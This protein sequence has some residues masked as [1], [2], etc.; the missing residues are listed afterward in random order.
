MA[1]GYGYGKVILFGEHFVVYGVP[2]IAAGV[3]KKTIATVEPGDNPGA[4]IIDNRPAVEG[5]KEKYVK[6][7]RESLERIRLLLGIDF[8]KNPI[9]ITL[10]GD[11]YCASGVGASAAS[12]VAMARAISQHFG[13]GLTEEQINALGLEG[14]KA[15]ATNPSGIDNT[16]STYGGLVY[17]IKNLDGGENTMDQLKLGA[18]LYVV[19]GSTG[20]TTKTKE[21]ILK[22]KEK[23]EKNPEKFLE[24]LKQAENL[25]GKARTALEVGDTQEIG[26]LMNENHVLLQEIEVSCPELDNLV[27]AARKAG[28]LGAK[29]TGGGMGGYMVALTTKENQNRV[30]EALMAAGATHTIKAEIV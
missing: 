3:S 6:E 2:A 5:Y 21:A 13:L 23:K 30:S 20:I 29:M 28:A 7:Q 26:K 16:V 27:Q 8:D 22:V 9:K 1:E 4:E 24:L 25:V 15:Y 10:A 18:P 11:L 12:C 19:M 17:F 14:D